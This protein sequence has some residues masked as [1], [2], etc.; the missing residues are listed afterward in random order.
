[1][2]CDAA[3]WQAQTKALAEGADVRVAGYGAAESIAA[4]AEAVLAAAPARFALA[5]HSMG[6]R[7]ALEIVARAPERVERL[8][9]FA[10]DYRG[11]A[12][13]ASL[14]AET[15]RRDDMLAALDRQGADAWSRDFARDMIGPA[16]GDDA[17]LV[18]EVA[19]M[20][21]RNAGRLAAHT[22]AGLHRPDHA[23]VLA[24][25]A[26]PTLVCAGAEDG[27]RPVEG[28]C[29]MA[30]RIAGARLVVLEGCG[31]MLAMEQPDA[32]TAALR[33]WLAG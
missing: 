18:A 17:R 30:A 9:L 29:D 21:A 5:G 4:M 10:T 3:F 8:G 28:H 6:G 20:F 2:L 7:V 14:R 31:H 16:R 1:M 26:C 13:A 24:R 23:A 19:A 11:P 27:L 32:V 15:L 25:I 12:D 22:L 33:D